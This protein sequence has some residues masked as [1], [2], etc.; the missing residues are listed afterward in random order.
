MESSNDNFSTE[1]T[2]LTSY[3]YKI[4]LTPSQ[5]HALLVLDIAVMVLNLV[6]NS[7]VLMALFMSKPYKNIIYAIILFE[8]IRLSFKYGGSTIV[9]NSDRSIF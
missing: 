3:S 7:A 4:H 2:C 1:I 6:T 5:R 9:R 8:C